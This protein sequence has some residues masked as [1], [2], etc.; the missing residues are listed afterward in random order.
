MPKNKCTVCRK[1]DMCNIQCRCGKT[2][3]LTHM[4]THNCEFDYKK[5]YKEQLDKENPHVTQSKIQKI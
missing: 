1:K 2:V 4:H 5:M 3:C